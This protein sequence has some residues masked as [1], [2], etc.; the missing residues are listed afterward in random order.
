MAVIAERGGE[1]LRSFATIGVDKLNSGGQLRSVGLTSVP[2]LNCRDM[3]STILG[4]AMADR[5]A[6]PSPRNIV[7]V[8]GPEARTRVVCKA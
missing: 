3:G 6:D 2:E 7:G 5:F 4:G 8:H 1:R